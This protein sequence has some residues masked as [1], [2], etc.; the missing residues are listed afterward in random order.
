MDDN[1]SDLQ[2]LQVILRK[3]LECNL[4][5]LLVSVY[6]W[7]SVLTICGLLFL[8]WQQYNCVLFCYPFHFA[9]A[10]TAKKI[11]CRRFRIGNFRTCL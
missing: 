3:V 2:P 6:V 7:V 10:Q 9:N 1:N 8:I 11:I 5:L 4:T